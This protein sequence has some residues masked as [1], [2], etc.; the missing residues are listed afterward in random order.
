MDRLSFISNSNLSRI[1]IK[2]VS[3]LLIILVLD[4]TISSILN[5]R[6]FNGQGKNTRINYTLK[7][8]NEVLI[9]GASRA[10]HHYVPEIIQKQT[11]YSVYNAGEDSKNAT[12]Q[13]GLL[14]LII[15]QYK[16]KLIIY[17]ISDFSRS[18]DRG[19]TELYPFYYKNRKIREIFNKRD[20]YS[21]I[22]F[23]MHL[24]AYNQKLYRLLIDSIFKSKPDEDGYSPLFGTIRN[25]EISKIIREK[26]L[27]DEPKLD[28]I[29]LLNFEEFIKICKENKIQ[30]VFANSPLYFGETAKFINIIDSLAKQNDIPFFDYYNDARFL[31]KKYLFKDAGH[32]NNEGAIIYSTIF[33]NDLHEYLMGKST[34][35]KEINF[36]RMDSII[37]TKNH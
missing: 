1:L 7:Q 5:E 2:F 14:N 10:N 11:G 29:T 25:E 9:F 12:Y 36:R 32:M 20:H 37:K 8:R 31:K 34:H 3:F 27:T 21:S 24:Y 17:E 6:F 19:T 33:G 23:T 35:T 30:L 28:E 15:E 13:L 18:F 26:S 22:K 4:L 16:P